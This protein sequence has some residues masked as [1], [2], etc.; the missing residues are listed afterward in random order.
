MINKIT[1]GFTLI[2]VLIAL[3]ILAIALTAL[4]KSMAQTVDSMH[5]IK[6]KTLNHW[7]AMQGIRM[8]QLGLL[9]INPSQ[10][11][12]QDTKMLGEHCFWRAQLSST[13]QK[14]IQLISIY[15]SNTKTGPFQLSLQGFKYSK[16]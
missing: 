9:N 15:I 13:S 16:L 5:R 2:E 11:T 14:N 1:R 10:E 6:Q 12:T 7:V 4:L 8:V 3:S